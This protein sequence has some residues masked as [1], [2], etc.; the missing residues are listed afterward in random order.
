MVEI[1]VHE[2]GLYV[3]NRWVIDTDYGR[4]DVPNQAEAI[5]YSAWWNT[6]YHD[7]GDTPD[8]ELW[9]VEL[10]HDITRQIQLLARV[11]GAPRLVLN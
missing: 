7:E 4:I 10:P 5:F 6:A 11:L 2:S 8:E 3:N 1:T 9:W